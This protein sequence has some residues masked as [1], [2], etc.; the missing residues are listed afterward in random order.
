MRYSTAR[1]GLLNDARRAFN[2]SSRSKPISTML[3]MAD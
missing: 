3:A 1:S 2:T